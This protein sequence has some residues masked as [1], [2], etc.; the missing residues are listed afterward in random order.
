[1]SEFLQFEAVAKQR[2]NTPNILHKWSNR[3]SSIE[4]NM[5]IVCCSSEHVNCV[6][7]QQKC[8]LIGELSALQWIFM[9]TEHEA[10]ARFIKAIR[11]CVRLFGC[12]WFRRQLYHFYNGLHFTALYRPA[13]GTNNQIWDDFSYF[14]NKFTH[15]IFIIDL[16]VCVYSNPIDRFD[17]K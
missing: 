3:L 8:I 9:F 1:M 17:S 13:S 12:R 10:S 14:L 15:R 16:C 11:I 6:Y 4:E 2:K 7:C 5:K